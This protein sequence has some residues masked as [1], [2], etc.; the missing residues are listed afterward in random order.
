MKNLFGVLCGPAR[1]RDNRMEDTHAQARGKQQRQTNSTNQRNAKKREGKKKTRLCEVH[2]CEM[3]TP[4]TSTFFL[5]FVYFM[6][7]LLLSATTP[8]PNGW[9]EWGLVR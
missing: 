5:G 6:L 7:L 2:R 3:N 1:P 9:E 4:S 8:H